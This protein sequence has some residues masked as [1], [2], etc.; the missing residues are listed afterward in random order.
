MD[1]RPLTWKTMKGQKPE[2]P[3]LFHQDRKAE[4]IFIHNFDGIT[5]RGVLCKECALSE[6]L[7]RQKMEQAMISNARRRQWQIIRGILKEEFGS[8]EE[9]SL[10]KTES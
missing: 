8:G 9:H 5:T 10:N 2:L 7:V 1:I 6:E 3:C 4:F